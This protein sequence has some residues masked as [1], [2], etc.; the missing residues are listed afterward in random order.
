MGIFNAKEY[1]Y[2]FPF[3]MHTGKVVG[4]HPAG[5]NDDWENWLNDSTADG[6]F[7]TP[8]M[9]KKQIE[10]M[11]KNPNY[12]HFFSNPFFTEVNMDYFDWKAMSQE[13]RYNSIYNSWVTNG[14][15]EM[16]D[17]KSAMKM[18]SSAFR[19][20]KKG[21]KYFVPAVTAMVFYQGMQEGGVAYGIYCLTPA[22]DV[23]EIATFASGYASGAAENGVR[24][25]NAAKGLIFVNSRTQ[26]VMEMTGGGP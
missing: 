12:S 15:V 2:L 24:S 9:V 11:K 3:D 17:D 18:G 23:E 8:E 10:D 20:T 7:V 16:V 14:L 21:A 22:K 25:T 1:G 19:I 5:W 4:L 13:A 6:K 26:Y